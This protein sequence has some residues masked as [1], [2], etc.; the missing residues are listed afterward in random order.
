MKNTNKCR[1]NRKSKFRPKRVTLIN[2]ICYSMSNVDWDKKHLYLFGYKLRSIISRYSSVCLS[3]LD[4]TQDFTWYKMLRNIVSL[5]AHWYNNH[6]TS[7]RHGFNSRSV[8][9]LIF[10]CISHTSV[11]STCSIGYKLTTCCIILLVV[12]VLMSECTRSL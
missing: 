10:K 8:Q 5:I 11:C 6:P 1:R 7:G 3:T 12:N 2:L 4:I 9:R